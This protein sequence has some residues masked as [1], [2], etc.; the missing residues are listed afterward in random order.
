VSDAA[1]IAVPDETWGEVGV[2]F[3]VGKLSERDLNEYLE[4][5]I[6]KYKVPRRFVFMDALPRTAYGKV[7]KED[8]RKLLS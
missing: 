2:A 3:V 7:V 4:M 5:R 8:L 1:V 6:A